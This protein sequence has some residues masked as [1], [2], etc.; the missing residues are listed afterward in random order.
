LQRDERRWRYWR[1]S[2]RVCTEF[3]DGYL[4]S[5]GSVIREVVIDAKVPAPWTTPEVEWLGLESVTDSLGVPMKERH[6]EL[7]LMARNA[8][9]GMAMF[10][11]DQF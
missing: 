11:T 7:H 5:E 9:P 1:W 10:M 4:C 3:G 8:P 6:F 2:L